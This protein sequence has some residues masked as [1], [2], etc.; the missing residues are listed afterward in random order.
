MA[1]LGGGWCSALGRLL[2]LPVAT[3][4]TVAM[5]WVCRLTAGAVL[6]ATEVVVMVVVAVA[7][8]AVMEWLEV[9]LKA[10]DVA[11]VEEATGGPP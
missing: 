2:P 4:E 9:P 7:Q 3:V 5:R 6:A 10:A 1:E 11:G 8:V